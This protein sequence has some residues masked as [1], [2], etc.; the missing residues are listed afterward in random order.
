MKK[1]NGFSI[2][3]ILI[4][5]S[6]II[7]IGAVGWLAYTNMSAPKSADETSE[8]TSADA[9]HVTVENEPDL[10]KADTALDDMNLEDSDTTE[11]DSTLASF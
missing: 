2:V 8:Q 10:D 7:L 11:F 6:V 5:I 9:P 1:I 3:E 4:V